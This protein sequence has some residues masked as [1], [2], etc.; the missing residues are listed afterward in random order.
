MIPNDYVKIFV[1]NQTSTEKNWLL[2]DF[3]VD[4]IFAFSKSFLFLKDKPSRWFTPW[5][6]NM[7]PTNHPFRRKWCS[8]P[9]WLCSILIFRGFLAEVKTTSKETSLSSYKMGFCDHYTNGVMGTMAWNKWVSPLFRGV[10]FISL[11]S[12]ERSHVPSQNTF[13]SMN[14][15]FPCRWDRCSR[16]L[17]GRLPTGDFRWPTL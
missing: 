7:E 5:K 10:I 16:S 17:E 4:F 11:P 3:Q 1:N 13:E 15:P 8:K 6:I 2:K 12:W 9:P 14:F